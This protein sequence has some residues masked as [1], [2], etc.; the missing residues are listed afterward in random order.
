MSPERQARIAR[1]LC[2]AVDALGASLTAWLVIRAAIVIAGG[3]P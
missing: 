2:V 1:A 3:A